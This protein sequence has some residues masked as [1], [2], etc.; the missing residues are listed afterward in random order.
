MR[1]GGVTGGVKCERERAERGEGGCSAEEGGGGAEPPP[2]STLQLRFPAQPPGF[3]GGQ[4]DQLL[5]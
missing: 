5:L 1:A 4:W 3:A 2:L